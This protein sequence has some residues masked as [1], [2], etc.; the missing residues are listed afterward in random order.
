LPIVERANCTGFI[1][2]SYKQTWFAGRDALRHRRSFAAATGRSSLHCI[3][4]C[5]HCYSHCFSIDTHCSWHRG[6][7]LALSRCCIANGS[8]FPL[9]IACIFVLAALESKLGLGALPFRG[10]ALGSKAQCRQ[11]HRSYW[12]C[13]AR[14]SKKVAS[15][16]VFETSD[17]TIDGRVLHL[18]IVMPRGSGHPAIAETGGDWIT[19][20]RG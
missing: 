20:L 9:Q 10:A 16:V 18:S 13:S 6:F 19:R 17:G 11:R 12:V 5:F 8:L 7:S 14:I 3:F 2:E 15:N 1:Q 4:H